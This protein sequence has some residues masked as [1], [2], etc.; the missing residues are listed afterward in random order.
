MVSLGATPPFVVLE[1]SF[2]VR[3]PAQPNPPQDSQTLSYYLK[4]ALD[5]GIIMMQV[6]RAISLRCFSNL[7]VRPKS[8]SSSS[9]KIAT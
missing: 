1:G 3:F 7:V 2:K 5:I 6:P 8:S 9:L 4:C